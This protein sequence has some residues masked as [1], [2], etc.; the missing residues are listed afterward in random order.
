MNKTL[1]VFF[2]ALV[3]FAF[4]PAHA[5]E[6]QE[7]APAYVKTAG[8]LKEFSN[9]FMLKKEHLERIT[10]AVLKESKGVKSTLDSW[11]K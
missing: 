10:T 1:T 9:P 5:H 4:P 8:I 3:V 7:N 11:T 2:L 6:E